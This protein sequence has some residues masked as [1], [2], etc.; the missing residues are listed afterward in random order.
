MGSSIS[1]P[2]VTDSANNQLADSDEEWLNLQTAA[3]FNCAF[4]KKIYSRLPPYDATD[5]QQEQKTKTSSSDTKVDEDSS[6]TMQLFSKIAYGGSCVDDFQ[7]ILSQVDVE[8]ESD[9]H[10]SLDIIVKVY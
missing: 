4:L 9:S 10:M 7:V 8:S 2:A 6:F 5:V 3:Y 1:V